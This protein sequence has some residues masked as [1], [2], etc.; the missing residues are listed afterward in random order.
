ME[1]EPWRKLLSDF[2]S[3]TGLQA[4]VETQ[5]DSL[6]IELFRHGAKAGYFRA[7]TAIVGGFSWEA[8]P[9]DCKQA[10]E[11]LGR[12]TP[13]IV[14]GA[15]WFYPE[16]QGKGWG[17]AIYRI[18]FEYVGARGGVIGPDR[19]AGGSTKQAALRV[20]RSLAKEYPQHGPW[21]DV[22]PGVAVQHKG[23]RNVKLPGVIDLPAAALYAGGWE[24]D[25]PGFANWPSF[26]RKSKKEKIAWAKKYVGSGIREP[27]DVTVYASGAFGF[28]DGHHRVMA[29]TVLGLE[30]PVRIEFLNFDPGLWPDLVELLKAGYTRRQYN[31]QDWKLTRTGVPPLE[32]VRRGP[33][34]ADEWIMGKMG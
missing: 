8:A 2:E 28:T 24:W 12:P 7:S 15:E 19:C 14:H 20:W 18:L 27:V 21:L 9:D 5:P 30:I 25:M 32:V 23:N 3:K 22:R 16:L 6:R 33:D 34:A 1:D 31:P 17:K 10:W 26:R 13:W 11:K 4:K 29:G